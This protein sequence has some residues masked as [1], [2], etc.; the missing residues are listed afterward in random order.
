MKTTKDFCQS[1]SRV[2]FIQNALEMQR[3]FVER[4]IIMSCVC[5][6]VVAVIIVVK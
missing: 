5:L 2:T 6:F 1:I 3:F 4:Q